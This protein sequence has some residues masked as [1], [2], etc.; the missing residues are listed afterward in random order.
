MESTSSVGYRKCDASQERESGGGHVVGSV[1]RPASGRRRRC[2]CCRHCR[3]VVAHV[4]GGGGGHRPVDRDVGAC[5]QARKTLHHVVRLARVVHG[6]GRRGPRRCCLVVAGADQFMLPTTCRGG[7]V[8]ELDGDLH[9]CRDRG[10]AHVDP[11]GGDVGVPGDV[12]IQAE[13]WVQDAAIGVRLDPLGLLHSHGAA[14]GQPAAAIQQGLQL[15]T[16]HG[17]AAEV[18]V[19]IGRRL[20]DGHNHPLSVFAHAREF[21]RFAILEAGQHA[22]PDL[23]D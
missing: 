13:V 7:R 11:D 5:S 10:A 22:V 6:D 8:R 9:G 2:R 4:G 17:H 21:L 1:R 18:Q 19:R 3:L 15:V 14:L 20:D 16:P 12:H 23:L